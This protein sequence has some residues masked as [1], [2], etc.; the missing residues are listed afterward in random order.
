[1]SGGERTARPQNR[2]SCRAAFYC[3][4]SNTLT[5]GE[6]PAKEAASGTFV[7]S[8]RG[9]RNAPWKDRRFSLFPTENMSRASESEAR[10]M[11]PDQ[12]IPESNYGVL[13]NVYP[14]AALYSG[15]QLLPNWKKLLTQ[16]TSTCGLTKMPPFT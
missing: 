1:M 10:K 11:F 15:A 4:A 5:A 16:W 3:P 2:C 14:I 7:R 12:A 9:V 13:P 8:K 6:P